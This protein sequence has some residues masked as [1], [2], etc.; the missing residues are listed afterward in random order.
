VTLVEADERLLAKEPAFVGAAIRDALKTDGVTVRT[1]EKVE[2]APQG[3]RVLAAMGK[4]PRVEGIGLE[5]LG[6]EPDTDDGLPV[7]E[8]CRVQQGLW[9]VGDV[10]SVAPEMSRRWSI[11]T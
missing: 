11:G 2:T 5:R 6:L 4:R 10:T 9:A 8:H 3:W 1:G 7:D